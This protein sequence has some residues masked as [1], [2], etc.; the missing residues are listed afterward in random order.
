MVGDALQSFP[1]TAI[2]VPVVSM[3]NVKSETNHKLMPWCDQS[4]LVCV[5]RKAARMDSMYISHFARTAVRTGFGGAAVDALPL[6]ELP[7]AWRGSDR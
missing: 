3:T 4:P 2:R 5:L 7:Q 6:G 1:G